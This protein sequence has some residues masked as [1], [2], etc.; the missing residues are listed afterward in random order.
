M[1][2][3]ARQELVAPCTPP[4]GLILHFP[5]QLVQ[6][7]SA[8]WAKREAFRIN[9]RT[10]TL[11]GQR[12]PQQMGN[13]GQTATRMHLPVDLAQALARH[14]L[15]LRG[16]VVF[17]PDACWRFPSVSHG[18]RSPSIWLNCYPCRALA[19]AN[20]IIAQLACLGSFIGGRHCRYCPGTARQDVK[21]QVEM[22]AG[23]CLGVGAC[24]GARLRPRI[25]RA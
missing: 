2:H 8:G 15:E 10:R 3:V 24:F 7:L 18:P 1:W 20:E 25:I 12:C 13:I 9:R 5:G 14:Q 4:I 6:C 22:P 19:V 17:K 21:G 23:T 16:F 11:L